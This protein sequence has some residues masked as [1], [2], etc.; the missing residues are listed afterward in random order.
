[1]ADLQILKKCLMSLPQSEENR[2]ARDI[3]GALDYGFKKNDQRCLVLG[4]DMHQLIAL[5]AVEVTIFHETQS[6]SKSWFGRGSYDMGAAQELHNWLWNVV[7]WTKH[8]DAT[9]RPLLEPLDLSSAGAAQLRSAMYASV[10]SN[11]SCLASLLALLCVK[12]STPLTVVPALLERILTSQNSRGVQAFVHALVFAAPSL[13]QLSDQAVV[14]KLPELIRQAF[15]KS[16]GTG[17]MLTDPLWAVLGSTSK[18]QVGV[19]VGMLC[20]LVPQQ[21]E[22]AHQASPQVADQLLRFWVRHLVAV[23]QWT[24]VAEIRTLLELIFRSAYLCGGL[25]SCLNIVGE[26]R[27]AILDLPPLEEQRWAANAFLPVALFSCLRFWNKGS[28]WPGGLRST[29]G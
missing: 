23:P 9:G 24:R 10:S 12:L 3:L 7:E 1:V 6:K 16:Q 27:L 4:A 13:V 2:C 26:Q 17:S 18:P 19:T 20:F 28:G 25:E 14:P 15:T 11:S 5:M 21:I 22:R 29:H 8:A